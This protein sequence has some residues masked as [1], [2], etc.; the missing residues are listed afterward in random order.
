MCIRDRGISCTRL[1]FALPV[2][3]MIPKVSPGFMLNVISFSTGWP[4][5]CLYLKVT[6]SNS[7]P[8]S[9]LYLVYRYLAL[10]TAFHMP[11]QLGL[12]RI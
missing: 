12:T 3:P 11:L 9:L 1:D 5:P 7:M 6:C 2:P 4:L 10:I 8:P